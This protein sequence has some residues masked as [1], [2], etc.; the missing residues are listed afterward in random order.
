MKKCTYNTKVLLNSIFGNSEY[1]F[2]N[3]CI[4]HIFSY[5]HAYI[6]TFYSRMD[7][8]ENQFNF[9][10]DN[11][12]FPFIVVT[13]HKRMVKVRKILRLKLEKEILTSKKS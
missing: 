7:K 6:S 5:V 13:P 3:K 10:V 12:M 11:R 8:R 4:P 9:E 2:L 1:I